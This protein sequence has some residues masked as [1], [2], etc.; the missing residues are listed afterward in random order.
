MG[1]LEGVF[2]PGF[3]FSTKILI[4]YI[5][6]NL[7]LDNKTFL[8]LGAGSGLITLFAASKKAIVKAS[9]VNIYATI[10]IQRN[11]DANKLRATVIHSDLFQDIL[12]QTFDFIVIN[13]PYFKKKPET[14]YELAWN[15]GENLEYFQNLFMQLR[16]YTHKETK[17]LM[18]LSDDCDI[19]RIKEIAALNHY[20]L[21][22]VYSKKKYWETNFIYEVT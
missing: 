5:D 8:E 2:H 19:M 11:L 16:P 10:N 20:S 13:P 21:K 22:E 1:V 9:D 6:K 3:F 17:T 7:E 4:D 15:A 14:V 18:I 12:P